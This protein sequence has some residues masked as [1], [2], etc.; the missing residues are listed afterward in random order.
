MAF[1]S[2]QGDNS[3]GVQLTRARSGFSSMKFI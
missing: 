2:L 3:F 1:I